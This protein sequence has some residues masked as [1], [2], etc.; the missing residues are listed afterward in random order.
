MVPIR[1]SEPAPVARDLAA[2][3][4]DGALTG[5]LAFLDGDDVLRLLFA[6]RPQASR[7]APPE[8]GSPHEEPEP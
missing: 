1:R 4:R 6:A 8:S 2:F 5:E 7:S 3:L